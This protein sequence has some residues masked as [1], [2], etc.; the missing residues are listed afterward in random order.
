V[1]IDIYKGARVRWSSA[2]LHP[3]QHGDTH[4]D[5]YVG[6]HPEQHGDTHGDEYVGMHSGTHP[7]A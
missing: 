2:G 4:G 6:M 7:Y 3:E 5:E 1:Y